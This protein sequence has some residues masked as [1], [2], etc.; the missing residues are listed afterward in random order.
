MQCLLAVLCLLLAAPPSAPRWELVAPSGGGAFEDEWNPGRWPM[1]V[2]PVASPDGRL[3]MV[4]N[5]T[6]W[7]SDDGL[8]W[9]VAGRF[10]LRLGATPLFHAGRLWRIGGQVGTSFTSQVW[11][12]AD[13]R[14]WE[15]AVD[16][17]WPGRRGA[18]VVTFKDSLWV[19]GG[20]RDAALNDAWRSPDGVRWT[21][22]V[23]HTPWPAEAQAAVVV[24]RDALWAFTGTS[25]RARDAAVWRSVD[26]ERWEQIRAVAPWGPRVAPGA[27]VFQNK[28]WIIGGVRPKGSWLNDVWTSNDGREWT[29]VAEQAPW[30]PRA[31]HRTLVYRD[32]LWLFGGKGIELTGKGGY[33]SD[34][35]MVR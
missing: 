27:L 16:A 31:G 21:R 9:D 5:R 29:R 14:H 10:P 13:A 23:G 3:W 18:S 6:A 19:I 35:W 30:T 12:S 25:W 7:E 11:S 26:G 17:P 32:R 15:R 8:R 33:A 34:V 20:E 4:G 2:Q 22:V 24:F 1:G 28:L